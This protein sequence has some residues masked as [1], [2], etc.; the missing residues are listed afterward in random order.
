MGKNIIE[1][2][3][4][5]DVK[6]VK[7]ENKKVI[8][9]DILVVATHLNP[10]TK[11][12][13]DSGLSQ[14]EISNGLETDVFLRTYIENV[15]AA[16]DVLKTADIDR[17][18]EDQ[19]YSWSRAVCQGKIAGINA[20]AFLNGKQDLNQVFDPQSIASADVQMLNLPAVCLG[21][22]SI[23][24]K[25]N[26][27]EFSFVDEDQKSYR[28]IIMCDSRII[29]FV[30][31]GTAEDKQIFSELIQ[32]RTDV[33]RIKDDLIDSDFSLNLLQEMIK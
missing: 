20:T 8:A 26:F 3:G 14:D 19:P 5:G 21:R 2:F 33:G 24:D 22:T 27:E 17:G 18:I 29:G 16:G 12:L 25:E 1:I 23:P 13:A 15:F 4:E 7:L 28:R 11:F 6:A 10:N 32:R 9:C 30:G 31:L